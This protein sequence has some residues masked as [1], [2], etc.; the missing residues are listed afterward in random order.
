[1]LCDDLGN[2]LNKA[3][4]QGGVAPKSRVSP[5]HSVVHPKAPLTHSE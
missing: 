5:L 2:A 3:A 1:M 4:S